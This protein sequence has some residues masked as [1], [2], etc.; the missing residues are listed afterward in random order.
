M[1]EREGGGMTNL[2]MGS[3]MIIILFSSQAH[4]F[5]CRGDKRPSW[6]C[7]SCRRLQPTLRNILPS[8][9]SSGSPWHHPPTPWCRPS[10]FWCSLPWTHTGSRMKWWIRTKQMTRLCP[11]LHRWLKWTQLALFII[12]NLLTYNIQSLQWMCLPSKSNKI[13]DTWQAVNKWE[14]AWKK[15]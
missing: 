1:S 3:C 7:T 15:H 9:S 14:A 6:S 5:L 10:S 13:K 8:A 11:E 2:Y 4:S 12:S